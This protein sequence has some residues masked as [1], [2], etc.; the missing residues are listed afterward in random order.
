MGLGPVRDV[1][2]FEA[3]EMASELRRQRRAGIDPANERRVKRATKAIQSSSSVTFETCAENFIDEN[4]AGWRNEK[5]ASQWSATLKTYAFPVLGQM[6][7]AEIETEHVLKV[8]K[9]IWTTKSETASRLRGRI[10]AI[11]D[12]AKANGLRAGDNPATWRG[13]LQRIL[14]AKSRVA[15]VQHHPAMPYV[16]IPAFL[17]RLRAAPGISARAL[18][19]T[20]LTAARTGE[21]IGALWDEIDFTSAAWTIPPE[22]TKSG[23]EHR[24]P[25]ERRA[26]DLLR[27]MATLS[28]TPFV[29][30]GGKKG[31]PLSN[32]SMDA[33]LRRLDIDLTVHGFRSSFRDWAA[34]QTAFS[35]EVAEACL[36]H[37]LKDRTEAA[38]RRSDLF[39]K[40]RELLAAWA[41]YCEMGGERL[42][43]FEKSDGSLAAL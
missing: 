23:R 40:R 13:H 8:L 34:D 17:V 4:R 1:T 3:R 12:Y 19:F 31:Q 7:V 43:N 37:T 21:V 20:I 32:M 16:N 29:F 26:M 18:E 36:A 39:G 24:V 38:Y 28:S 10:E 9:P 15:A 5:H 11:L 2:L 22:R 41:D 33:V 27:E 35:R 14:P 42:P 25:L 30:P 6:K